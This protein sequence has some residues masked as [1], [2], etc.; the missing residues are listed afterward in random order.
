M[1]DGSS[2]IAL[3]KLAGNLTSNI[4]QIQMR[5][6]GRDPMKNTLINSGVGL[7]SDLAQN[8]VRE[9]W[10]DIKRLLKK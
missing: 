10:P 2:S 1:D 4:V 5:P 7:S 9:F 6:Y 3:G 8:I